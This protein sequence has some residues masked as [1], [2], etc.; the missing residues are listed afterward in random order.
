MSPLGRSEPLVRPGDRVQVGQPLTRG[1][2]GGVC[3]HASVSGRVAAVEERPHPW[4][5]TSL[6]VVLEND[7]EDT[8]F[9]DRPQPLV[10]EKVKLKQ[11]VERTHWAGIAGMGGGAYP[12]DRKLAQAADKIDTLI[13]NAAE[14]EPYV[15][16]DHRLLLERSDH[17]LQGAQVLA[18]CLGAKRTVVVTEGDKLNAVEAV[19]RRLRKRGARG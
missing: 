10:P 18:R 9:E 12:T 7:G 4:G 15:T 2:D 17:I 14:C 8:P 19:E 11:L 16:A 1:I 6:A 5:G 13:V 3:V